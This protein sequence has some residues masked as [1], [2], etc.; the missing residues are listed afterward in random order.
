[1]KTQARMILATL[2]GWMNRKQQDVIEYLHEENRALKQQFDTTGKKLALN[3]CER[4][5]L[6]EKAK[7]SAKTSSKNT[8]IWSRRKPDRMASLPDRA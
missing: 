8:P 6:V 3:D 1:M 7:N 5:S 2:A 4:R